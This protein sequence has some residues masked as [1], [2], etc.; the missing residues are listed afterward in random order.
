MLEHSSDLSSFDCLRS[1]RMTAGVAGC[2]I[3]RNPRHCEAEGKHCT[4]SPPS[5]MRGDVQ[6]Q[7]RTGGSMR[8]RVASTETL[9]RIRTAAGLPPPFGHPPHKCGGQGVRCL[10]LVWRLS[11][12]NT[13]RLPRGF[14]PRNDSGGRR[15]CRPDRWNTPPVGV[16]HTLLPFIS[17]ISLGFPVNIR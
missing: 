16:R 9:R 7:R 14:A 11:P 12:L 1:L 13:R 6:A 4:L 10:P 8:Y 3:H 15:G 5:F 17:R 2:G